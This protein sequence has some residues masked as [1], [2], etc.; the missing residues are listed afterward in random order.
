[1]ASYNLF[2]EDPVLLHRAWLNC[3]RKASSCED[4]R[5]YLCITE[6]I[7]AQKTGVPDRS[8]FFSH[9]HSSAEVIN[10]NLCY[11]I[12]QIKMEDQVEFLELD[13]SPPEEVG[14]MGNMV[15]DDNPTDVI[16]QNGRS[17][18]ECSVHTT[19]LSGLKC[20]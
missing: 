13:N 4:R 2:Q 7:I 16:D 9:L 10:R 1:M 12:Q 15:G 14:A 11:E 20:Q 18:S 19:L 3:L 6:N 17:S 8:P 5:S